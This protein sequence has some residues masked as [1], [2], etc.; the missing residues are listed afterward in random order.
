MS[1]INKEGL[2][3]TTFMLLKEKMELDSNPRA[4]MGRIM[5]KYSEVCELYGVQA[6]P[7]SLNQVIAYT[8]TANMNL[9]ARELYYDN[10][11]ENAQRTTVEMEKSFQDENFRRSLFNSRTNNSQSD[12]PVAGISLTA[13]GQC[14]NNYHDRQEAYP[15]VS[16]ECVK[17]RLYRRAKCWFF[18]RGTCKFA[19]LPGG[20]RYEH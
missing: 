14:F 10:L 1:I 20:C 19:M 17:T 15:K 11:K 5:R 2:H 9:A 16:N 12:D 6:L 8:V 4:F 13:G 7:V 3:K 18:Q